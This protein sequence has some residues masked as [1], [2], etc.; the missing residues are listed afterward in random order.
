L[1]E[2]TL[3]HRSGCSFTKNLT[4]CI[5]F[6][7]IDASAQIASEVHGPSCQAKGTVERPGKNVRQKAGLNKEILEVSPGMMISMLRYE[8]ERAGG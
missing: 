6:C 8:A 7:T 2:A 1:A 5:H 3:R 4:I